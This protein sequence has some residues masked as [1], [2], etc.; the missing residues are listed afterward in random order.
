MTSRSLADPQ[1]LKT[2]YCAASRFPTAVFRFHRARQTAKPRKIPIPKNPKNFRSPTVPARRAAPKRGVPRPDRSNRL[3]FRPPL[4]LG[5]LGL[6]FIL[7]NTNLPVQS[8]TPSPRR[9][10]VVFTILQHH[11]P[12][13]S[14]AGADAS[15]RETLRAGLSPPISLNHFEPFFDELCVDPALE[16]T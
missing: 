13:F 10:V 2:P 11:R 1:T 4:F 9:I 12:S 14:L 8:P 6:S 16:S 15:S 5:A 3:I 7:P